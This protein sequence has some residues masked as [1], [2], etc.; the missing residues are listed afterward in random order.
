MIKISHRGNLDGTAKRSRK[1]QETWAAFHFSKSSLWNLSTQTCDAWCK[2]GNYFEKS[3][4]LAQPIPSCC[5]YGEDR[6]RPSP[7]LKKMGNKNKT[8]YGFS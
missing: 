7:L 5:E 6:Y 4:K 3:R 2:E 8:F 1:S